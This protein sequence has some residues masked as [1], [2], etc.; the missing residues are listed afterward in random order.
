[1][2]VYRVKYTVFATKDNKK[3]HFTKLLNEMFADM[4]NTVVKIK[5][6]QWLLLKVIFLASAV[7]THSA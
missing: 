7:S 3:R 6:L 5:Y 2:T 1:M 4:Q